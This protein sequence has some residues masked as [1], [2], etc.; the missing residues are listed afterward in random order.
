MNE[1]DICNMQ[2]VVHVPLKLRSMYNTPAQD[3][4]RS[5][6]LVTANLLVPRGVCPTWP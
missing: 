2:K 4:A 3:P 6:S 1:H 5:D